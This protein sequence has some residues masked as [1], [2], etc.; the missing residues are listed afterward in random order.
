MIEARSLRRSFDGGRVE[1]L[2]G[3][4]L[5]IATGEFVAVQGPSGCGK[6]TLL[7]IIGALDAPTSGQVLFRGAPLDRLGD[8]AAFRSRTVG[9]IFQGSCL[10]PTLTAVENVQIPMFET[11]RSATERC[12]R[13]ETL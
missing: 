3:V 4:T 7:H 10:L 12:H 2:R 5:A 9:F 1:A 8:P 11:S 6:S 13:A